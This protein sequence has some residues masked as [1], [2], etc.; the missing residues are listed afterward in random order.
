MPGTFIT[1][2]RVDSAGH[3]GRL[4]DRLSQSFGRRQVF[5]DAEGGIKR[6]EDFA[7]A[8]ARALSSASALVVLV[9]RN[10]LT[11]EDKDGRR[12]LD[13]PGDWVHDEIAEALRRK[14]LVLPVLVDGASMPTASDLPPDIAELALCH[15]SDLRGNS[16][17]YDAGQIAKA[18]RSTIPINRRNLIAAAITA[19]LLGT[20]ASAWI[21]N[22]PVT[23]YTLEKI[24]GDGQTIP[25]LE[26][27]EFK[28]RVKDLAGAPLFGVKIAWTTS[29]CPDRLYIGESDKEGIS[30][31]TNVC[32][33]VRPFGRY[34]QTAVPVEVSG[35]SLERSVG[36]TRSVGKSVVFIFNSP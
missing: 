10:W 17:H 32:N 18:L 19:L 33:F 7:K 25:N 24:S 20:G 26:W 5:I 15:A 2:R 11:C 36:Q 22:R 3:A 12:R 28:V 31:A 16:W 9:G 35:P 29:A 27:R 14:I 1:Y 4:F 34:E 13:I 8:I 21:I 30:S 6:G 23:L